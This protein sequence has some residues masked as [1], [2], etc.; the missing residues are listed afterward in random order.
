MI[1]PT[2]RDP[3]IVAVGA[4]LI[5]RIVGETIGGDV[6]LKPLLAGQTWVHC[7][8]AA[9]GAALVA[10]PGRWMRQRHAV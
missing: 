8:A 6:A 3:V 10:G 9:V 4:T 1:K 7:V 2:S 5:G